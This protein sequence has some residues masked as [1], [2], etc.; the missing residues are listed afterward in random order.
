MSSVTRKELFK[1]LFT[2]KKYRKI[3]IPVLL[4]LVFDF[5][6]IST[7]FYSSY[8]MEESAVS[9]N[10]SGRQRML[11][12]RTTKALLLL[13]DDMRRGDTE[14]TG[15]VQNELKLVVRLFDTTLKGFRDGDIVTGGDNQPVKLVKVDTEISRK[16]VQDAYAIWEPYLDRLQPL[17]SDRPFTQA[18]LDA[19]AAYARANNL[20]LLRLMN[21]LTTDLEKT[22]TE[23]AFWLRVIQAIFLFAAIANVI[24]TIWVSMRDLIASDREITKARK[25]TDEILATVREGLFLLDPQY[26]LGSQ[27]SESLAQVLQRDVYSGM[28]FLPVLK[29]M[30][31]E[32]V[33]GAAA[34]YIELLFGERVKEALITSLNPLSEV[35]VTTV[36]RN[37]NSKTHYLNF[38]FNR[39]IT[40]GQISHLLVTVQDVTEQIL[41]AQ[42]LE[43]AKGQARIEIEVLLRLLNTEPA[44]LQQFLNNVDQALG[45]INERLRSD[46]DMQQGHLHTVNYIM[47]IIHGIK[48]EAAALGV[49]MFEAYAHDCEK[50]LVTIRDRGEATGDD[51]VRITVLLEGFYERLSSL[52][53][54]VSRLSSFSSGKHPDEEPEQSKAQVFVDSL[55]T[56]AERIAG[57]QHK[58]ITFSA[59]I[60]DLQKLP[61]RIVQE[62]QGIA[63]QL[64]RNAMAHGIEL[65]EERRALGKEESGALHVSCKDLG[66]YRFEF[67]L[68]DDGRGIVADR[69]RKAMVDSGYLSR[70]EANG[71]SDVEI[72]RKLFEPG[73]STAAG[74]DRDAGHGIGLDVVHSKVRA[75]HGY[76]QVKSRADQFTEFHI[77]FEV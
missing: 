74:A 71:L 36:D 60:D 64:V 54:I 13:Q 17:L 41:L 23:R 12:Q 9:I 20:E 45:Q 48:G 65:P 14:D 53:G 61:R 18:Q 57:D 75:M 32:K 59:D 69:L 30:V 70:E 26:R 31:P 55:R 7:N 51:M 42:Q 62:L 63:I 35:P 5:T 43:Q 11:S 16:A 68:R 27:F 46:E 10:L 38:H 34:D 73:V 67:M 29:Q 22:A 24:Y 37:G 19:A 77:R 76:L 52:T 6:V 50:E 4:F 33:Y 49:E 15:K 39:A 3:A 56:L 25:E 40:E 44:A 66:N 28:E 1:E 2:N 47:R 58:K 21:D 72:G 8:R